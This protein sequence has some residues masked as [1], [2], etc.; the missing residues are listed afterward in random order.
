MT[1]ALHR[2]SHCLVLFFAAFILL[3]QNAFSMSGMGFNSLA[4][5]P[6]GNLS[7]VRIWDIGVAWNAIHIAPDTFD[8]STLDV[9]VGQIESFGASITYVVG[10]TPRWLAKYPDNPYYAEWLGPGSNSMPYDTNEFNNF[11]TEVAKRYG[12]RIQAFEIWN[13]PQLNEFLYPYET[14]ELNCLAKMTQL[15]YN[16]IKSMTGA[17]VLAASV[18]PRSTSGGMSKASKYL[19]AIQSQGW[20][21]DA[22]N[23]HIYP[24]DGQGPTEWGAMLQDCRDTLASMSAPSSEVWVTETNYNYPYGP[25]ISEEDA[26]TYVNGAFDQ[27]SQQGVSVI[28]WYAWN[29][30]DLGGMLFT[31]T[32]SAWA[33]VAAHA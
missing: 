24:E 13:E 30:E 19:T 26:P 9:V 15:A 7:S 20:N 12:S 29:R 18:L 28:Y 23:T 10:A 25:R 8:F 3:I 27:A 32:S 5:W 17:K 6:G 21:V 11:I 1:I 16:T 33:S 14:S 31:Q 2:R 4:A 22:F